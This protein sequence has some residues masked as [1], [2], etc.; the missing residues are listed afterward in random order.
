MMPAGRHVGVLTFSALSLTARHLATAGALADTPIQGLMPGCHFQRAI[1]EEWTGDP[2]ADFAARDADV[3]AAARALMAA[4]PDLGAVL[5][6]CT[7]FPPH[8]ET[9]AA[10]TGFPVYDIWSLLELLMQRPA[11]TG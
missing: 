7:N 8:R 5:L 4:H 9:I 6:E 2:A 3:A 11:A 10:V 1:L